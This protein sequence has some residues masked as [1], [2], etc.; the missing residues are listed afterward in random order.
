M[1]NKKNLWIIIGVLV[2]AGLGAAYF[3]FGKNTEIESSGTT[4]NIGKRAHV[5]YVWTFEDG[6]VFDTNKKEI[7]EKNGT[8]TAELDQGWKYQPLQF[9]VGAGQMIP[10]FDRAVVD[11]KVWESKKI[12][13]KPVD[14]Y[15]EYNTGLITTMPRSQFQEANI[16]PKV[17][18][19]YNS[20]NGEFTVLELTNETATVDYN[21]KMAGKTLIFDITLEQIDEPQTPIVTPKTTSD[22]EKNT[23]N[24]KDTDGNATTNTTEPTSNPDQT[25]AKEP[26]NSPEPTGQE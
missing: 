24:K 21:S 11:M 13:L 22:E 3:F 25:G 23:D 1:T 18:D 26:T 16:V 8:Y 10:W 2:L 12:T 17:G 15:G 5:Y 6:S 14:A 19:V 7:A 4:N 9:I 20:A